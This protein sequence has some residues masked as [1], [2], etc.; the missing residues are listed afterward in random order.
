VAAV[1]GEATEA[2]RVAGRDG[3]E[4]VG[5]DVRRDGEREG[6]AELRVRMRDKDENDGGA[7][8]R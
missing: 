4:G 3:E 8:L 2:V 7:R 1:A 5:G 6:M